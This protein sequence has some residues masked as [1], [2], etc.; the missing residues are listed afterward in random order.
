MPLYLPTGKQESKDLLDDQLGAETTTSQARVS[1][2]PEVMSS[3]FKGV[4][5]PVF[6]C[7]KSDE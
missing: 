2:V 4:L 5:A 3:R 6:T 1:R 7:F